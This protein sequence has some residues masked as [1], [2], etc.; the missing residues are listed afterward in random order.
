[1]PRS[2]PHRYGA[3]ERAHKGDTQERVEAR[4]AMEKKLGHDIPAGVDVDHRKELKLG[5]SND[6]SN[7]RLRD[8]GANRG[9]KSWRHGR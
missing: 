1:M 5:G 7:L 2:G 9:D 8:A 6:M 4:R 3:Y